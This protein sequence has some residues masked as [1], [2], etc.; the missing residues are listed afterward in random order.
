VQETGSVCCHGRCAQPGWH[1]VCP[2]EGLAWSA[3]GARR[4]RDA[5]STKFVFWQPCERENVGLKKG[6]SP[7]LRLGFK[8][9]SLGLILGLS[10]LV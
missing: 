6:F 7:I 8:G 4:G 9:V 5:I 2:R 1:K 3:A 10:T